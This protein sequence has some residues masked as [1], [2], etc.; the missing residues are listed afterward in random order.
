MGEGGD[1]DGDRTAGEVV[2]D[3][4]VPVRPARIAGMGDAIAA[5][6]EGGGAKYMS[7]TSAA[8]AKGLRGGVGGGLSAYESES[9]S[10]FMP[11]RREDHK[12]D[13]IGA[14]GPKRALVGS[15]D[16]GAGGA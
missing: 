14:P 5:W 4:A 10:P 13:G 16:G 3:M 6:N 8:P 7:S 1:G 9:E 11:Y 12:M 15:F 2:S